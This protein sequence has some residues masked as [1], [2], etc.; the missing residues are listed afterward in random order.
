MKKIL[1]PTRPDYFFTYWILI[2]FVLYVMKIVPYNPKYLFFV[3]AGLGILQLGVMLFFKESARY[4][5]AFVFSVM[6]TKG[7]PI[8]YLR[9]DKTTPVDIYVM[10]SAVVLFFCWLIYN[11]VS[12]RRFIS[13][14]LTPDKNG[15]ISFPVTNYIYQIISLFT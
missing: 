9:D 15:K 10:L 1:S 4:L 5:L 14:Y 2:W 12:I 11:G 8:Y 7:I 6:L 3:G 13:E